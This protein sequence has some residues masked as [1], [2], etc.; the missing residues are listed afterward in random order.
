MR[1]D[2]GAHLDFF[3][4][5]DLLLLARFGRL[6]LVRVFQLAE[7]EDLAHRRIIVRRD[8]YEVQSCFLGHLEGLVGGYCTEIH[9]FGIDKLD[10][11]NANFPIG[12]RAFL[13]GGIGF[14]WSANGR[15]LLDR[16][17]AQ[18]TTK[19]ARGREPSGMS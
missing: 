14:E 11:G 18:A 9:A 7:V 15:I 2:V 6:L 3:D 1:V 10:L 13:D 5:D 19:F 12:A 8:F 4:F 17:R 16:F